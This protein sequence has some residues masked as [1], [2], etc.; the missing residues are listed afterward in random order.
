MPARLRILAVDG[1]E[2]RA[3]NGANQARL[4][5]S[6]KSVAARTSMPG[7]E[8]APQWQGLRTDVDG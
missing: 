2:E 6:G 1:P 7:C 8:R 5:L 3:G 4:F